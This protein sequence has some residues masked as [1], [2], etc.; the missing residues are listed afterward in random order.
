MQTISLLFFFSGIA[1]LTYEVL[2]VRH[3]GLVFGNTVYA[4]ATVMM[5]YIGGKTT[6]K[7]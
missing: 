6:A 3:L 7:I 5:T 4:A 2:W 1:A